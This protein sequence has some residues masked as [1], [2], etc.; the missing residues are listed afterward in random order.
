[1]FLKFN[2]MCRKKI[3]ILYLL[4]FVFWYRN[5]IHWEKKHFIIKPK[6]LSSFYTHCKN[7]R[8]FEWELV[9]LLDDDTSWNILYI[10][11]IIKSF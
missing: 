8:P 3:K 11:D 6:V 7:L 9:K 2:S 10:S 5:P 4:F 1:M